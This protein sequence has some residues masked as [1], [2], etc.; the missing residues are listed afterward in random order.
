M[1]ARGEQTPC[2]GALGYDIGNQAVPQ[3]GE[4]IAGLPRG[5][6]VQR[7]RLKMAKN[8]N[9]ILGKVGKGL[10]T[11]I[12]VLPEPQYYTKLDK[13]LKTPFFPTHLLLH[14]QYH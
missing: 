12:I 10:N 5:R 4:R 9:P 8:Q 2:E 13:N 6:N 1:S 14:H 11:I 7:V 3:K